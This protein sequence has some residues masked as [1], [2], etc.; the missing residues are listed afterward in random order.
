[1]G[2]DIPLEKFGHRLEPLV[3]ELLLDVVVQAL[4]D[5]GVL[6]GLLEDLEALGDAPLGLKHMRFLN[7]VNGLFLLF[8]GEIAA[9]PELLALE[10][11]A[12]IVGEVAPDTLQGV[13]VGDHL[14]EID[15]VEPILSIAFA[16]LRIHEVVLGYAGFWRLLILLL[17]LCDLLLSSL[18]VD[19]VD[20]RPMDYRLFQ[21][22]KGGL[23]TH[24]V[25]AGTLNHTC[26]QGEPIDL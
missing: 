3:F 26:T 1:M 18:M 5:L 16:Y 6:Q 12:L 9:F 11:D 25:L 8:L 23:E 19:V 2:D 4:A 22:H 24:R 7:Q 13:I 17:A 10:D 21:E 14:I 15:H 20:F